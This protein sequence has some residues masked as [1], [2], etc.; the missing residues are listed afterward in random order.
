[1]PEM[2]IESLRLVIDA[3]IARSCGSDTADKPP[4][5]SCR[6]FL[7]AVLAYEHKVV[8]TA[9]IR[10]EWQKHQS[11]NALRWRREMVSRKR[12]IAIRERLFDAELWETIRDMAK[13]DQQRKAM[14]KDI[15]LLEAALTT[16]RTHCI[17]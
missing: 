7:Y 6:D 1:M 12:L 2:T 4:G 13:S 17:T 11:R 16:D 3:S 8:M 14:A 15:L 10:A 9:E 5:S